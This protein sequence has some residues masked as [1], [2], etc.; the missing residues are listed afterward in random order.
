MKKFFRFASALAAVLGILA[1]CERVQEVDTAEGRQAEEEVDLTDAI[2]VSHGSIATKVVSDGEGN[3]VWAEGDQML[4]SMYGKE[5]VVY[6]MISGAG[7]KVA[8]FKT[9]VKAAEGRYVDYNV[10]FSPASMAT[11][12]DLSEESD[13]VYFTLPAEQVRPDDESIIFRSEYFPVVARTEHSYDTHFYCQDICGAVGFSMC[14]AGDEVLKIVFRGNDGEVLCGEARVHTDGEPVMETDDEQEGCDE[15]TLI[16]T[17]EEGNGVILDPETPTEF[18]IVVPPTNF[19]YGFT[20]EVYTADG[21]VFTKKTEEEQFLGRG[22]YLAMDTF[23]KEPKPT[24]P[25]YELLSDQNG[26]I[27]QLTWGPDGITHE[28]EEPLTEADQVEVGEYVITYAEEGSTAAPDTIRLTAEEGKDT[29]LTLALDGEKTYDFELVVVPE[30]T[31]MF[32]PSLPSETSET[33]EFFT[34]EDLYNLAAGFNLARKEAK[35]LADYAGYKFKGAIVGNNAQNSFKNLLAVQDRDADCQ[36][37]G[38]VF[39]GSKYNTVADYPLG[40][41]IVTTIASGSSVTNYNGLL[42]F[43]DVDQKVSGDADPVDA[44]EIDAADVDSTFAGMYVKIDGLHFTDSSAIRTWSGTRKF[45]DA[46]KDTVTVYTLSA[47]NF[48]SKQISPVQEKGSISGIA[49]PYYDIIEIYPIAAADLADFDYTAPTINPTST[50]ISDVA[51]S[52]ASRQTLD[53][54]IANADGW[55]VSLEMDGTVVTEPTNIAKTDTDKKY[56][57]TYYVAENSGFD[58]SGKMTVVL[59]LGKIK[60][61]KDIVVSQLGS[62]KVSTAMFRYKALYSSVTEGNVVVSG[63]SDS[64]DGITVSYAK[65]DS[66]NDCAYYF[67]G[68]SLRMYTGSQLTVTSVSGT[69]TVAP[70]IVGVQLYYSKGYAPSTA[71]TVSTGS[72]TGTTAWAPG[73]DP[74]STVVFT[75]P[76]TERIDSIAVK[77]TPVAD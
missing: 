5:P 20:V 59:A 17:D 46:A 67:N 7:E 68:T 22:E 54:Y 53:V 31:L 40:K 29:V 27:V 10:A 3:V 63:K 14:G 66:K 58:R 4:V 16:T 49:Y 75:T 41:D 43:K 77:F 60:I 44:L 72:M 61:T 8:Y 71:P 64:V 38:A 37:C 2:E 35:S 34:T 56:Q 76:A 36:G 65:G 62:I 69:S 50:T 57:I 26:N 73:D 13:Y 55:D 9:S 74:V 28:G 45:A 48:S 32:R 47:A 70:S 23:F 15:L 33:T 11:E 19:E 25:S 24:Y 39:Y 52:G 21:Y 1:G 18:V 6:D 12:F 51:A 42:E 30:D